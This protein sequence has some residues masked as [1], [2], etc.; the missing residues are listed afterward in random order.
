[1]DGAAWGRTIVMAQNRRTSS[2]KRDPLWVRVLLTLMALTFLGLFLAMP[3][4]V[5]FIEAFQ[6]GW[7]LWLSSLKDPD[8]LAAMRLSLFAVVVAVP[9]NTIFGLCA[10]WVLTRF[11][12]KG[13]SALLTLIDIPFAVSP[14][15]AGMMLVLLFGSRGW[16]GS[17][18][19]AH[20]WKIVFATPGIILA[21][22]FVTM[23]FVARELI[24]LMES[25]GQEEEQAARTLGASGWQ[26][27]WR[28]TLPNIKWALLYGII[29][30][31]ARAV[32]EFGAVSVVSGHITGQTMTLPL[33]IEAR[34]NEYS[35][36]AAFSAA[37][38]LALLA[39]VTLAAK[40][41]IELRGQVRKRH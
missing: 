25:Q 40:T 36:V 23:P 2:S 38:V 37:S 24:P 20:N 15:I 35:T 14:V 9:M 33:H 22:A 29:L 12:F 11:R 1:M 6:Q 7:R 27:F 13:R 34:Y 10:A 26:T 4:C 32:G 8:A 18:L 5:V 41:F 28:V 30:C 31:S 17:Y 39:L 16:F 21:T 3:L 19:D